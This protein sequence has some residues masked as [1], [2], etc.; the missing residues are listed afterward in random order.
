MMPT[1][2]ARRQLE[3]QVVDQQPVAEAL[4]QVL[5]L[6]HEVAEARP[7]RD[8]DFVGLLALLEFLRD[9]FLEAAEARLALGLARLGVLR[10]PIPVRP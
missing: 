8:V 3:A 6:D 4:A 1:M 2:R 7:G 10:A 9:E 5:D